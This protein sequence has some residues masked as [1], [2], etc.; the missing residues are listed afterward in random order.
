MALADKTA[1]TV[2]LEAQ[3]AD[4][5]AWQL[6]TFLT[7]TDVT[8]MLIL[9]E[10]KRT[11]LVAHCWSALLGPWAALTEFTVVHISEE[12]KGTVQGAGP[13]EA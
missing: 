6:W 12:A 4:L 1:M 7:P 3:G 10:S 13:F 11:K 2:L 8:A 9:Q 5:A